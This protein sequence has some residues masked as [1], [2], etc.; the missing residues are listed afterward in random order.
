MTRD[1]RPKPKFG[2]LVRARR[3]HLGLTLTDFAARCRT[4]AGNLSRIERGERKPPELPHLVRIA[5]ALSI[6]RDSPS[7]HQLMAAA[8]RDRFETLVCAGEY[9][10]SKPD[11][12]AFL[13]AAGNL[14]VEPQ[15]CLVFEDTDMGI[16]AATAGGM[17]SVKV[18]PPWARQQTV[19]GS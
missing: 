18:P 1:K 3:E 10:K 6:Q 4:D 14:G 12:E 19:I 16:Q 5:E 2:E 17:A 7:W 15:A 11:P 9:A 8:A 13:M